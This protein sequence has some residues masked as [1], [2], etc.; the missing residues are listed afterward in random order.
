[1]LVLVLALAL[2]L[3]LCWCLCLV[4]VLVLCCFHHVKIRSDLSSTR[5]LRLCVL[6]FCIY[7]AGQHCFARPSTSSLFSFGVRRV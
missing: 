5:E 2:A 3:A 1:M 7:F 6:S 4:L